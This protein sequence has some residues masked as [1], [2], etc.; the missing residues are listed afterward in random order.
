MTTTVTGFDGTIDDSAFARGQAIAHARGIVSSRDSFTATAVAN[1]RQV[2][3][4]G[5]KALDAGVLVEVTDAVAATV[6]VDPAQAG[7]WSL[8]V[9]RRDWDANTVTYLSLPHTQTSTT[10]PTAPPSGRPSGFEDRP[11]LVADTP[12]WWAWA[13]T[14]VTSLILV[15]ARTMPPGLPREGTQAARTAFYGSPTS[16]AGQRA[17]QGARWFNTDTNLDEV[18]MAAYNAA[19]NP[20]GVQNPGTAGWYSVG[21]NGE[22]QVLT[23]RF[24]DPL[25]MPGNGSALIDKFT[26]NLPQG[27]FL[28]FAHTMHWTALGNAAGELVAEFKRPGDVGWSRIEAG[29]VR[30]H[31]QGGPVKLVIVKQEYDMW[32]PPG[33]IEFNI[34]FRADSRS[35]GS[36]KYDAYSFVTGA[37]R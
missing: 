20:G 27:R 21:N 1:A 11:G 8:I 5:G 33:Q 12:L 26:L 10:V 29:K 34:Y 37:A 6:T 14:G 17:L 31:S 24:S 32:V 7:Q 25:N 18:Y 13:L 22:T 35:E 30:V 28:S 19:T 4:S 16:L 15:D 3:L 36:V 9:Q 2:R 23:T